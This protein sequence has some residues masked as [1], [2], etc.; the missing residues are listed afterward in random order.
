[1]TGPTTARRALPWLLIAGLAAV[2]GSSVAFAQDEEFRL[3]GKVRAGG[4]VTISADETVTGDLYVSGG[5]ITVDGT[6]EGDLA[7]AGGQVTVS[8]SVGGDLL[9]GTGAATVSGEVGGD[10]RIGSGQVTVSGSIG[11]DLAVGSG[12]VTISSSGTVGEDFVFATGQT[13]LDGTVEGDVSGATGDYVRR[14]TVGGTEDVEV[15]PPRTVGDRV[16][17]AVQRFVAILAIAALLLWLYPRPLTGGAATLRRRPWASLGVG[18]LGMVGY[19]VVVA[20]FFV[21]MILLAI[22]FGFI[23]MEDLTGITV[24]STL[25]AVNT[26]TYVAFLAAG[27]VAHAVVGLVIGRLVSQS[28]TGGGRWLALILG[29]LLIVILSALPVVG[30]FFGLIASIFGFGALILE[31]WPWRR[32]EPAPATSAATA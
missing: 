7:A 22:G 32:R 3:G 18:L 19:V 1:M 5:Q 4:I 9:I 12:Q 13:T 28:E 17:D 25:T 21:V 20:V 27:F 24:F 30:W 10:A 31:F 23:G 15:P 16:L 11:E 8:G 2:L 29:V 6:V 14:G 26:L